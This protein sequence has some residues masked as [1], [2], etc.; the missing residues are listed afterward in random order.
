FLEKLNNFMREND[1]SY[2]MIY[3]SDHGQ[4]HREIG[5][6]IYFNNNRASKLHFDVPLFMISSDDDSRHECK[7]FKSGF[8]FVN[9]IASWVG[10]KNKKIDSNYS[11][12]DCNDDPNDF[13]VK[14][15]IESIELELDPAIDLRGK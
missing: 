9:G 2:S 8:N 12:F 6:E 15:Y 3:F 11:L 5:G 1:N 13:G 14:K 7:S 10:I 4:A